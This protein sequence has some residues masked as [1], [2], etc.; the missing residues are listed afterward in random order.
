MTLPVL[1]LGSQGPDVEAWQRFLRGRGTQITADGEFGPRTF[2]ATRSYQRLRALHDDGVVGSR[3]WASAGL[4][5]FPLAAG[6]IIAG[7]DNSEPSSSIAFPPYPDDLEPMTP[8]RRRQLFGDFAFVPAPTK[9]SPEA[10]RIL[11]TWKRDNIVRVEIA[12]LNRRFWVHRLVA[13]QT[14]FE[15]VMYKVNQTVAEGIEAGAQSR[16]IISS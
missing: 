16:I 9:S 5:G 6:D 8:A 13:A 4:Q 15:K 12:N 10:I 1:R 7:P 11:G 14:N 3:T 2:S